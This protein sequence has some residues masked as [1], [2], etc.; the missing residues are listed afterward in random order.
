MTRDQDQD[1]ELHQEIWR[2]FLGV[3]M[4]GGWE[5][6]ARRGEAGPRRGDRGG[7][8]G[9]GKGGESRVEHSKAEQ[10]R[11]QEEEGRGGCGLILHSADRHRWRWCYSLT[12]IQGIYRAHPCVV[13]LLFFPF[14]FLALQGWWGEA[15]GRAMF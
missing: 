8:K 4:H 9:E 5:E 2:P 11:R 13:F 12:C 1:L 15:K 14:F 7:D 3:C 6:E 10:R